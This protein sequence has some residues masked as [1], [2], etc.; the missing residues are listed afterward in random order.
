MPGAQKRFVY[1]LRSKIEPARRHVGLTSD[2]DTGLRWR[3]AGQNASTSAWKP[4]FVDVCIEFSPSE[5]VAVRFEKYLKS[6]SGHAF[7]ERHFCDP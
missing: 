4:W 7:A 3:N 5:D 1:I 6:G 2:I